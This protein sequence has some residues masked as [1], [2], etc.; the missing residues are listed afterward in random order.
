MLSGVTFP[1]R[2]KWALKD[3]LERVGLLGAAYRALELARGVDL[4][5]LVPGS[6]PP[7]APDGLPLPPGRL[8]A[9]VAGTAD[10]GWF[11]RSG[12]RDAE[13]ITGLLEEA[14]TELSRVDSMLD[15]GC[16]CGRIA[17]HWRTLEH[18]AFEGVDRNPR[19]IAWCRENLP[20]GRFAV[21]ELEPPLEHA[22]SSFD[23]VY[24]FSVFT[25]FPEPLQKAWLAELRRVLRPGGHLLFTTHGERD[26]GALAP[27]ERAR[28]RAGEMIVRYGSVA[29]SNACTAY[30]PV[31][32][33]RRHLTDGF[34][35]AAFFK[36]GKPGPFQD[37]HVLRRLDT[38]DERAASFAGTYAD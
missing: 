27:S 28:F 7:A 29:G 13:A 21:N 35:V 26:L 1:P 15:F 2:L 37:V 25:H 5:E 34:E 18:V 20:F 8:R 30:H 31:E 32:Y 14:G 16:G 23:V 24:A 36:A 6:S 10:V 3:A 12:A 4:R 9:M 17:R 19:L 11:L 22:A 38:S 33:V